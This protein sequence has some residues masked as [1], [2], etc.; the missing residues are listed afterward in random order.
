[1]GETLSNVPADLNERSVNLIKER[2]PTYTPTTWEAIQAKEEEELMKPEDERNHSRAM[3]LMLVAK[4]PRGQNVAV[5]N[6][7]IEAYTVVHDGMSF[8]SLVTDKT[9][10]ETIYLR[11]LNVLL[12]TQ[13]SS[14]YLR[15]TRKSS[16]SS[17]H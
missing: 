3:C 12:G 7:S 2:L 13:L 10:T 4:V 11:Y 16:E 6:H 14:K 9:L 15:H 8:V 17:S 1:M 5:I